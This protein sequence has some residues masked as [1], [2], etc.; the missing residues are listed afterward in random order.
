V[1]SYLPPQ[2]AE[3]LSWNPVLHGVEWMRSAYY[4]DYGSTVLDRGYMLSCA[5][6]LVL[7]GLL[8]ERLTRR[9]RSGA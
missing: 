5:L 7:A 2:I 1:P 4:R 8:G 3:W 9:R 6:L